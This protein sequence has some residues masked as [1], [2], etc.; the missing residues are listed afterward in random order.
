MAKKVGIVVAGAQKL[1]Y[2]GLAFTDR[3]MS[4]NKDKWREESK[5]VDKNSHYAS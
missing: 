3:R 4:Q 2:E 5:K 1:L